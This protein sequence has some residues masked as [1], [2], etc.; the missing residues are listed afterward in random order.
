MIDTETNERGNTII[1]AFHFARERYHYDLDECKAAKG[2]KQYDTIQD[3][4]YFGVWV[5]PER[6]EIV[7]FAEGDETRVICP[8]AESY[9]AELADMAAFYG[10][11]PPAFK[12]ID[13]DGTLT[14]YY[15]E[16]PD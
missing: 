1:R 15:D 12:T 16:R 3:A 2:W 13:E 9:R 10:P 4:P 7:T 11:P 8:T 6:R 14:E 5:H